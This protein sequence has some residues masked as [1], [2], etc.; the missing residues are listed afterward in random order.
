MTLLVGLFD[1]LSFNLMDLGCQIRNSTGDGNFSNYRTIRTVSGTK[2]EFILTVSSHR[3]TQ[4]HRS[5]HIDSV[6]P[7]RERR[8]VHVF[9]VAASR[10]NGQAAIGGNIR[11]YLQLAPIRRL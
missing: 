1:W 4:L 2:G 7:V 9:D 11:F 5:G 8:V 6:C 10:G 3:T